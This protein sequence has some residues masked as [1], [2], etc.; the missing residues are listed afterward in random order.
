MANEWW[1]L[2]GAG[3]RGGGRSGRGS[4]PFKGLRT[5]PLK[6]LKD[7]GRGGYR[8]PTGQSKY[9]PGSFLGKG[10]DGLKKYNAALKAVEKAQRPRPSAGKIAK[11]TTIALSTGGVV[12]LAVKLTSG[13]GDGDT[14]TGPDKYIHSE[15]SRSR[16]N[17]P[18][19][20]SIASDGSRCGRRA[21]SVRGPT[22]GY[23]PP[24]SRRPKFAPCPTMDSIASDGSRCGRRAASVRGPTR[25]YDGV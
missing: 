4:D 7:G 8:A 5:D 11:N 2:G 19:M 10:K 21:A 15:D 22:R 14:S 9:P 25:G 24:R 6:D 20:N 1:G 17:C 18:Y 16:G 3:A 23:D 12:A 13:I